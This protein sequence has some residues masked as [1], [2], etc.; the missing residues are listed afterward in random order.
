MEDGGKDGCGRMLRTFPR[1]T[2]K[3]VSSID[4]KKQMLLTVLPRVPQCESPQSERMAR[5]P[6]TCASRPSLPELKGS[7]LLAACNS[8]QLAFPL[9]TGPFLNPV[10]SA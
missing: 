8:H 4:I 5:R 3:T 6:R 1:S 2:H 10:I 9:R 7:C